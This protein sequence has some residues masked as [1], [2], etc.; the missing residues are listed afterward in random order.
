MFESLWKRNPKDS[1]VPFESRMVDSER[2]WAGGGSRR[3]MGLDECGMVL[4]A[5][6]YQI[7]C[8]RPTAL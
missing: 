8:E 6:V 1:R 3:K 4:R 2:F 7:L 5:C